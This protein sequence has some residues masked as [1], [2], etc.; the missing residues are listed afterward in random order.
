MYSF[1]E[2][3]KHYAEL[4]NPDAAEQDLEFLRKKQPGLSTLSMFS[5]NPKRYADDILYALLDVAER[6]EIRN[7]RRIVEQTPYPNPE[8]PD[9]MS[10][11]TNQ[12]EEAEERTEEAELHTEEVEERVQEAEERA[13]EAELR[14]EEA[15]ERAESAEAALEEEKKKAVTTPKMVKFKSTKS[16]PISTGTT[17]LTHKS[18]R[19]RS[20]TTTES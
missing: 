3:Q 10:E 20:S 13:E 15:E 6:D 18:K 7:N 19:P 2:K 1:K 17:S 9:K 12:V 4:R 16:T 11:V 5:R 14:A 8:Q